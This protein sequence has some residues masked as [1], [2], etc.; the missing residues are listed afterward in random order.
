MGPTGK[1]LIHF[2]HFFT[3]SSVA[4]L[5]GLVTFP[6][7]TR[8]LPRDQYGMLGLITATA[9]IAVALAKGGLSDGIIRFYRDYASTAED[10]EV[11]TSTVVFRGIAVAVVVCILY[12]LCVPNITGLLEVDKGYMLC[13]YVMLP[14]VLVRPLNVIVYNYLRVL[15]NTVLF[16]VNV[17]ATRALGI[18][19]SLF[20]LLYLVKN[21]Y[22]FFLGVVIAEI[23]AGITLFWW[24]LRRYRVSWS[25]VSGPLSIDLLKFGTPLVA[26]E[27]MFLLLTY[28]DRYML[29]NIC[30]E[31]LLGVY[32]VGYNL[33]S[34]INDL[35]MFSISNAVVPIYTETFAKEGRRATEEFLSRALRYYFIVVIPLCAIYAT[36][37]HDLIVV[38]ASEKYAA[39]ASFSPLIMIGLVCLGM[40]SIVGA[41]M[42]LQKKT[43]LMLGIMAVALLVNVGL[44]LLLLPRLQAMGAA[45]ATLVATIVSLGLTWYFGRKHLRLVFPASTVILYGILALAI[46]ALTTIITTDKEWLNLIMEIGLG[47]GIVLAAV[48]WREKDAR[49]QV[50]KFLKLG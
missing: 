48:L 5:L 43:N 46:Y 9:S 10:R 41:G 45:I 44:N 6:I 7:L 22:G 13:F 24:L 35:L 40:N 17:V 14:Y 39:A 4:M 26:T 27:L 8:L 32:S 42:Y 1:L 47:G 3:G 37:S 36:I 23:V 12:A 29:V 30:G 28:I 19:L 33:P 25:R 11:F 18:V 21:L 50:R 38:V 16:N 15:G 20:L 2:S 31:D 34:Y 49:T